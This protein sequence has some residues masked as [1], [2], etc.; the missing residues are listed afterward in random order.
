MTSIL[1]NVLIYINSRTVCGYVMY[2][3]NVFIWKYF[4]CEVAYGDM[5]EP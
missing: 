5:F 2:S 1:N 4:I 3:R